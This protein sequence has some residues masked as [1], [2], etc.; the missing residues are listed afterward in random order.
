MKEIG[1]AIQKARLEK[2]LT[3]EEIAAHTRI[4]ISHLHKIEAGQFDFLPRPYVVA[5]IKTFAQQVELNGEGLL[6]RWREQAQAEPSLPIEQTASSFTPVETAKPKKLDTSMPAPEQQHP[7]F[8]RQGQLPYLKEILIGLAIILFMA[9]L[10]YL[11]FRWKGENNRTADNVSE[12]ARPL[13]Q[14]PPFAE[15]AKEHAE[16]FQSPAS[17]EETPTILTLQAKFDGQ[18]WMRVV[19]D[20]TDTTDFVYRLGDTPTWQAREKFKINIGNSG[21]VTLMLDGKNLG[22]VG[23]LGQVATLTITRAGIVEKR[24][25]PPRRRRT[26][27]QGNSDTGPPSD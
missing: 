14:E 21:A 16:K 8:S 22:K 17:V 13:E 26:L 12:K 1:Q 7:Q 27:P 15:V 18:S 6:R 19:S 24:T 9:A 20:G 11:T 2:G 10:M 3:L 5:F 25:T 4:Q 23:E